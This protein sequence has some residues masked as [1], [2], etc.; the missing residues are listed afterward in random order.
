[1]HYYLMTERRTHPR[2]W[3][4]P[5]H[6]CPLSRSRRILQQNLEGICNRCKWSLEP[7]SFLSSIVDDP[8]PSVSVLATSDI[9]LPEHPLNQQSKCKEIILLP[10]ETCMYRGAS[11]DANRNCCKIRTTD[12]MKQWAFVSGYRTG[13]SDPKEE[14]LH[15]ASRLNIWTLR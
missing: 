14:L 9:L 8:Y 4:E 6:L 15:F 5:L 13:K 10:H 3:T 7:A 11:I 2:Q 1:M 12:L